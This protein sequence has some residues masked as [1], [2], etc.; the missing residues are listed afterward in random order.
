[1]LSSLSGIAALAIDCENPAALAGF[2]QKVLGGDVVVDEDG[3]A[4]LRLPEGRGVR[5]DFLRVPETKTVKNRL[6][7]DLRARDYGAAVAEAVRLGATYADD[8]YDGD[9]W[10]VLRDPEGNEFCILRPRTNA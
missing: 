6:H 5:L 7:L 9:E 1:M 2:W 3:D 4:E 10:Q 8:I